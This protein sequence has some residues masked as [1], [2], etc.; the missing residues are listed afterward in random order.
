MLQDH[1]PCLKPLSKIP[2]VLSHS[3]SRLFDIAVTDANSEVR[4]T[5]KA[6]AEP[7]ERGSSPEEPWLPNLTQKKSTCY[8]DF[9]FLITPRQGFVF[10]AI[11]FFS[12]KRLT[13]FFKIAKFLVL[14]EGLFYGQKT[15]PFSRL[16]WMYSNNGF[17]CLG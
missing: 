2:A 17:P 5:A 7:L 16:W 6:G 3:T 14:R 12:E 11:G 15:F 13:Y 9:A 1:L 4:K 8:S 10:P